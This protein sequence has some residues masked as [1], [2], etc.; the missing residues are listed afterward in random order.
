M[1]PTP[2]SGL[3]ALAL[4]G[5]A[6]L[7]A[8]LVPTAAAGEPA[9]P[10][11]AAT[12]GNPGAVA[13]VSNGWTIPWGAAWLPGGSAA[14]VTERNSFKV[15]SVTPSGT[16]KE[17]GT[18]PESQTTGGEGGLM[19]IAVDPQ[20]SANRFVYLMHTSS[21]GNRIARMTY[22][23]S[24]LGGYRKL[25]GDIKKARFHNGGALAFGPDGHLYA[26]T[27][28][29]QVPALAQ[30][31]NSLNGKILRLTRDGRPAPGNP[32]DSAVF[33]LGHRNPQ[34]LA[35]DSRGRLWSAELGQSTRDE[36]NLIKSGHNYGWPSC[37]GDCQV[38]GMTNPKRT[39]GVAEASPSGIA[40]V[41]NAVYMASLRGK[42]LWQIPID[43]ANENTGTPKAY[44]T[45]SYGRL[46]SVTRT[47]GKNEFWI[48][49]TNTDGNGG[50]PAGSDRLLR[51][52]VG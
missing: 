32:F 23:G 46:R 3:A 26:A 34:G 48:S 25:V 52:T 13:T 28:D 1:T 38:A 4:T 45:N 19:G 20:W 37:E 47:P 11:P 24:T 8:G 36:L 18:V 35:F 44:Y 27:G 10:A 50:Q 12:R 17:I 5:A 9:P 30:D 6:A 51:V 7:L 42:R 33:S 31:R 40:I 15:F 16:K 39:W 22:D 41:D 2:R 21:E 49:T 14:L 29:A 43:P